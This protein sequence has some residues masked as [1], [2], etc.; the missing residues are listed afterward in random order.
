MAIKIETRI[1]LPPRK[2]EAMRIEVS[3]VEVIGGSNECP[4]NV[5]ARSGG[6]MAR[7]GFSAKRKSDTLQL[8]TAKAMAVRMRGDQSTLRHLFDHF[9]STRRRFMVCLSARSQA[10]GV[11]CCPTPGTVS[12]FRH[13]NGHNSRGRRLN[14]PCRW[15]AATQTNT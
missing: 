2:S 10:A 6:K 3:S 9:L 8:R 1:A 7:A 4:R 11:E 13:N 12:C 14:R 15:G 5:F